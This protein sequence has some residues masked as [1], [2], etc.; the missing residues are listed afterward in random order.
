MKLLVMLKR[1][2]HHQKTIDKVEQL[3]YEHLKIMRK[4]SFENQTDEN[5]LIRLTLLRHDEEPHTQE[6]VMP[7]R[8]TGWIPLFTPGTMRVTIGDKSVEMDISQENKKY[9]IT[10]TSEGTLKEARE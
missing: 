3:R 2:Q 5:L 4:I 7:A 10:M 9:S 6:H 1:R 8:K